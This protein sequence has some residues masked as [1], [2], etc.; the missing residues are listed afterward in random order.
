MLLPRVASHVAACCGV[1]LLVGCAKAD[2]PADT[3]AAMAPATTTSAMSGGAMASAPIALADVAGKWKVRAVPTSGA[4]TSA[5]EFTLTAT[6]TTEG[7]KFA[8]ANGLTVPVRV[9]TSGDSIITDA[10]PYK[11]IRRKGVDVT[12]HGVFRKQGDKLVGTTI[13]HYNKG[14]D[15]VLTLHAEGMRAP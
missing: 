4:D 3:T 2:K 9:T 13:A 7:W 8:F 12:T 15:S 11:S 5:T 1:I 10:G 14:A 6:G